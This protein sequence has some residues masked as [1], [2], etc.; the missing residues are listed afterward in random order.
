M[1]D[2]LSLA[3]NCSPDIPNEGLTWC[4]LAQLVER[5]L[6]VRQARVRFQAQHHWEGLP[7]ELTK[8]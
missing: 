7:T 3:I 2:I 6:A 8:R 5:R 1:W 4:G